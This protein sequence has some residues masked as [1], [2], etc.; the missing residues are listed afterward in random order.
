MC[1]REEDKTAPWDILS[2]GPL[3][4]NTKLLPES[5]PSSASVLV[6]GNRGKQSQSSI[7]FSSRARETPR[8]LSRE[9][10][11]RFVLKKIFLAAVW[12]GRKCE[13]PALQSPGRS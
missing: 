2:V 9:L 6:T 1:Q 10:I 11:K 7:R 3:G 12:G 5:L 4:F 13:E 8:V